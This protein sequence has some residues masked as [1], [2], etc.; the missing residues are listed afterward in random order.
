MLGVAAVVDD[1]VDVAA[2]PLPEVEV[3]QV[4]ADALAGFDAALL[5]GE[6]FLGVA[7]VDKGADSDCEGILPQQAKVMGVKSYA[8]VGF[9]GGKAK[10]LADVPIH[11]PIDDMQI[12]EDFQMIVG[13]TVMQWLFA[14][15]PVR[16]V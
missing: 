5:D 15:R 7:L 11:I 10:E 16:T 8:V 14:N 4:E 1:E 3:S 2:F 6:R 9:G 12:A 13:H